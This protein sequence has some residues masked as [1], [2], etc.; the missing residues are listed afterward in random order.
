MPT[1][2]RE[3]LHPWRSI[4]LWGLLRLISNRFYGQGIIREWEKARFWICDRRAS[5]WRIES[6]NLKPTRQRIQ[7]RGKFR[8][9]TTSMRFYPVSREGFSP[10]SMFLPT[11]ESRSKIFG[12][13]WRKPVRKQTLSTVASKM[14][15]SSITIWEGRSIPIWEGQGSRILWLGSSPGIHATK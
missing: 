6:S 1:R 2:E 7:K 12:R 4:A 3:R 11:E 5:P 15:A 13:A 9:V 14:M 8:S 10:T